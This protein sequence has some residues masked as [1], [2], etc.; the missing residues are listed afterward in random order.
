MDE[1]EAEKNIHLKMRNVKRTEIQRL[2]N[3][4]KIIM[5]RIRPEQKGEL[6]ERKGHQK[7]KTTRKSAWSL[8]KDWSE[9]MK[10]S[11]REN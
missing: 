5:L 7:H 6:R 11:W 1:K 4:G 8:S 3:R 2:K 9:M 10:M